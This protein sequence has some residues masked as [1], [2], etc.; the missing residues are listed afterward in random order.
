VLSAVGNVKISSQVTEPEIWLHCN[1]SGTLGA[2]HITFLVV[3]LS[4]LK[5]PAYLI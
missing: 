5:A 2:I 3:L 4:Y 1:L